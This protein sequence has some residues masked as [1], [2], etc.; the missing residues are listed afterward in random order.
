MA[1]RA[2]LTKGGRKHFVVRRNRV[3]KNHQ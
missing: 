1:V 2:V 3:Q